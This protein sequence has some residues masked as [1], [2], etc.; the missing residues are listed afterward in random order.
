MTRVCVTCGWFVLTGRERCRCGGLAVSWQA[1]QRAL[2]VDSFRRVID[3]SPERRV[4]AL[5]VKR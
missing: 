4:R 3:A 1:T 2:G 5:A